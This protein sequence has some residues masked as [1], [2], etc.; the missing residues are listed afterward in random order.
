LLA[1]FKGDKDK[2]HKRHFS[3]NLTDG[4]KP[5]PTPDEIFFKD[6]KVYCGDFVAEKVGA[7]EQIKYELKK[8]STYM[9]EDVEVEYI[10][11][12][13]TTQLEK[14]EIFEFH[15]LLENFEVQGTMKVL[16]GDKEKKAWEFTGQEKA[17]QKKK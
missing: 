15:C 2:L 14:N 13:A 17:K 4:K 6:G 3:I 8:D 10:D 12:F 11:I 5:K 1:S 7:K 16:K 9:D